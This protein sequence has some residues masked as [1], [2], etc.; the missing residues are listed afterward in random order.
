MPIRAK[1]TI[2]TAALILFV[3]SNGFAQ[4]GPKETKKAESQLDDASESALRETQQLLRDPKRLEK[5]GLHTPE[6]KHNHQQLKQLMG[7][8]ADT[9]AVYDLVAEIFGDIVK[10]SDGNSVK[11]LEMLNQVMSKPEAFAH[12]M[13]PEQRKKLSDLAKKV[14]ARQSKGK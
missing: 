4:N 14:E 8:D 11:M 3:G 10:E 6:A 2:F 13:S 5:E 1:T 7:T 9:A 12:R